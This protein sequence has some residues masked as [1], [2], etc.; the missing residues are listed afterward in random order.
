M[1]AKLI[2]TGIMGAGKSRVGRIAAQ[3]LGWKF[4]DSDH[5]IVARAGKPIPRIFAEDGEPCFR[6]LEREII[7]ELASAPGPAALATG[8]GVLI[9]EAN[10][11]VL[12]AAG[13]IACLTARP[14]VLA[15]RLA[16]SADQRPKLQEAGKPLIE[17]IIELLAERAQAYSRADAQIDASDMTPEQAAEAVLAA[18][19]R[20]R[21]ERQ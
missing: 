5:E 3:R 7:N 6:R 17:R 1:S 8:G 20:W 16:K 19:E 4:I 18:F 21:A 13:F 12:S 14:E 11:R 2:L 15:A 9:D 10:Y